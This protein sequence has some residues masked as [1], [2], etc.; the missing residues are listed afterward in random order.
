MNTH[1]E[2]D[3][4]DLTRQPH[5]QHPLYTGIIVL[6]LIESTVIVAFISSYL[7]LASRSATWRPAGAGAPDL[8]LPTIS[9]GLL[10]ASAAAMYK[11]SAEINKRNQKGLAFWVAAA[12]LLDCI[13]LVLRF[14]QFRQFDVPHDGSAYGSILWTLSGFHFLHVSS[15][16][17]GSAVIAGFAWAGYFT[18]ERQIGVIVDT[19]YWYFVSL[20]WI[21][22]YLVL[23]WLPRLLG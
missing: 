13:V 12:V 15:A 21:P 22:L 5:R 17:V 7:Y 11:G 14:L 18:K 3:V 9:V 19:L 8:L 1:T 4:S 10:L 2:I 16:I 6:L 20:A 23:Y